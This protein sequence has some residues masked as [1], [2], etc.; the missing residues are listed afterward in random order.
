MRSLSRP[1]QSTTLPRFRRWSAGGDSNGGPAISSDQHVKQV[2]SIDR[3]MFAGA[4]F[5]SLTLRLRCLH[6]VDFPLCCAISPGSRQTRLRRTPSLAPLISWP[7][8]RLHRRPA[9]HCLRTAFLDLMHPTFPVGKFLVT[10]LVK[11]SEGGGFAASVS[12][13]RGTH[14]R[15]F[16]FV[17]RFAS[18][19]LAARYAMR[20]GRNM[21]RRSLQG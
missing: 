20:H 8:L 12:I 21:A 1:V 9:A 2:H 19:A 5:P 16:R 10:P 4:V 7:A 14:D 3:I 11:P 15:V 6:R 18:E 13:R 17:P